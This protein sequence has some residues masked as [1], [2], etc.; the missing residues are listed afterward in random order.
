LVWRLIVVAAIPG[1]VLLTAACLYEFRA[2]RAGSI[3]YQVRIDHW[4]EEACLIMRDP[5]VTIALQGYLCSSMEPESIF[6]I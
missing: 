3:H 2:E 5:D 4:R 1:L 6:E